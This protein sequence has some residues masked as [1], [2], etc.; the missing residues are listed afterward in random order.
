M[1]ADRAPISPPVWYGAPTE[2]S[3]SHPRSAQPECKCMLFGWA[4]GANQGDRC[5]ARQV[6]RVRSEGRPATRAS[7]PCKRPTAS[8]TTRSSSD[9]FFRVPCACRLARVNAQGQRPAFFRLAL[10]RGL[11]GLVEA[12]RA[13]P[14]L[15]KMVAV[16]SHPWL[17]QRSRPMCRS[18]CS[19]S[20]VF[21]QWLH[22][23]ISAA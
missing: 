21:S 13:Q 15:D 10:P 9:N 19:P 22:L 18:R 6:Q 16:A 7:S 23:G 5:R 14:P 20:L 12:S 3:A 17:K 2:P 8:S 4:L 1:F 11:L